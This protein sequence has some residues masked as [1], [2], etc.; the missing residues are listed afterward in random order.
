[1]A[2]IAK[3]ATTPKPQTNLAPKATA[4]DQDRLNENVQPTLEPDLDLNQLF[5]PLDNTN[6]YAKVLFWGREGTSKTTSAAHA[7]NLGRVLVINA[8]AGLKAQAL[9]TRGVNTTNIAL[10]PPQGSDLGITHQSLE[11]VYYAVKSDLMKDPN[12]WFAIVID[13]ITEVADALV[14][15]VSDNRVRQA[16]RRAS[17]NGVSLESNLRWETDRNDYGTMAKQFRDLLRKFRDLPCHLILTALER[18][19]VDEDTGAVTYGPAVSPGIQKDVLGYMDLV[20]NFAAADEQRPYRALTAGGERRRTKDRYGVM[21]RVLNEPTFDRVLGYLN[22]DLD[23]TTDPLQKQEQ[24]MGE[25]TNNNNN[26]EI[27]NA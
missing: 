14:N 22:G 26:K 17:A 1:M 6:D 25:H 8:E 13:S 24:P 5:T 18:R 3:P 27:S 21:P 11:K 2:K 23:E 4:E 16:E 12:S 7:A 19:D 15:N 20:F 9:K 10:Y